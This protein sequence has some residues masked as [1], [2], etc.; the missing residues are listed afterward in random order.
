MRQKD[1]KKISQKTTLFDRFAVA[2]GAGMITFLIGIVIVFFAGALFD[3]F[4]FKILCGLSLIM[5]VIG[6]LNNELAASLLEK[7][8]N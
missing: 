8:M 4:S 7:F 6:F 1:R 3:S 5:A 2:I